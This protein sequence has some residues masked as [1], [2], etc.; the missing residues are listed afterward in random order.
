MKIILNDEVKV[1]ANEFD[2][3]VLILKHHELVLIK[4]AL[5]QYYGSEEEINNINREVFDAHEFKNTAGFRDFFHFA[6]HGAMHISGNKSIGCTD[7]ITTVN[8]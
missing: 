6:G 8:S 4:K 5:E 7:F 2:K 3:I 1:K